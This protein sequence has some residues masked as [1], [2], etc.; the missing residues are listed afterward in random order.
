MAFR[1]NVVAAGLTLKLA[2][3]PM[4]RS[5]SV[6]VLVMVGRDMMLWPLV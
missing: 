5:D 2:H 4:Q 6:F 1:T 3:A